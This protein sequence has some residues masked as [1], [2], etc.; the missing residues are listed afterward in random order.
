MRR[1]GIPALAAVL[2]AF[3]LGG[4]GGGSDKPELQPGSLRLGAVLGTTAWD[5]EV[6]TGVRAAVKSLDR[7]GGLDGK[8]RVN[9]VVGEARQLAADG[10]RVVVLPCDAADQAAAAA[11]LRRHQ[12]FV[13]EPCNTG[14]WQRFHAV[15]PVSVSQTAEARVLIGYA[16]DQHYQRIAVIGDGRM[17]R[18]VRAA[19]RQAGLRFAAPRR[20]DAVVVALASPYAQAAVARL[21]ASGIDTPVLA[22]HGMD[23]VGQIARH[24]S[25]LD[26]VVFTAFGFA[27]PGS[28]LDELDERYRA[29]TGHHPSSTVAALGYDAVRVLDYAAVDAGS[30]RPQSLRASMHGLDAY[31]ATGKISYPQQG[32]RSPAVSVA[33]IRINHGQLDLVDRFDT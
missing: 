30:T 24:R 18:A 19:A 9:L 14:L 11:T 13:L 26:G 25:A 7:S 6:L 15:W 4:C 27:D 2:T 29:L 20:A 33:L 21:R 1:R 22:T 32:A 16:H 3:A 12:G 10:V 5:R 28:E 31:G 17:A 23:D 8:V